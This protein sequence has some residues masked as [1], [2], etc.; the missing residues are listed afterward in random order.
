MDKKTVNSNGFKKENMNEAIEK[1]LKNKKTVNS[2]GFRKTNMNKAIEIYSKNEA[3]GM[4]PPDG[5]RIIKVKG[6]GSC[7]YHAIMKSLDIMDPQQFN[8]FKRKSKMN[9]ENNDQGYKLRDRC[10]KILKKILNEIKTLLSFLKDNTI[11]TN[12]KNNQKEKLKNIIES[13][14]LHFFMGNFNINNFIKNNTIINAVEE[15]LQKEI[16][17]ISSYERGKFTNKYIE[18]YTIY[19]I[20]KILGKNIFIYFSRTNQWFANQ[21]I[22]HANRDNS[23]FIIYNGNHYDTLLPIENLKNNFNGKPRKAFFN[24]NNYNFIKR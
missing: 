15:F 11:N 3:S 7:G 17:E 16:N 5:W 14:K 12:I 9:M 2:N 21:I 1:S 4:I 24:K 13:L 18:G 6:D 23:L 20:Q 10:A 19:I 22:E 8:K